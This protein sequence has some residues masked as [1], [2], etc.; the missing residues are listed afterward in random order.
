MEPYLYLS[1]DSKTTKLIKSTKI[2][3]SNSIAYFN[4]DKTMSAN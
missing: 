4:F 3:M 1:F 2:D